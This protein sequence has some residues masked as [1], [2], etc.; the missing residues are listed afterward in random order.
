MF[1]PLDL[2]SESRIQHGA[3]GPLYVT[4]SY[5]TW[6]FCR[7]VSGF[8]TDCPCGIWCRELTTCLL[9]VG[10]LDELC[11][12][13]L[14]KW[15]EIPVEGLQCLV[16]NMP[17]RLAAIIAARCGDTRY[18]SSIHK[19]IPTG[20]I[21]QKK[22]SLFDQIYHNY[23]PMTFRYAHAGNS[24]NI[25]KCHYKF[26]KIHIKQNSAYNTLKNINPANQPVF[27]HHKQIEYESSPKGTS[28]R[29]VT[30]FFP[31]GCYG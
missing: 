27:R 31:R 17:W 19:T 11:Q 24:S 7:G 12:A 10:P 25:N 22:S 13:M 20:S 21:M 2:L 6:I 15:A 29:G 30:T 3:I 18:W 1:L 14:D 8:A 16:A 23:H 9:H 5:S 4:S 26:T 28:F